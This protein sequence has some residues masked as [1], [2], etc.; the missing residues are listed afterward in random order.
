[1]KDSIN[2]LCNPLE[3]SLNEKIS[4]INRIV[5]DFLHPLGIDPNSYRIIGKRGQPKMI[6][7]AKDLVK[8]E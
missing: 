7:A 2:R 6:M 5:Y 8:W 1:M 4:R 3:N